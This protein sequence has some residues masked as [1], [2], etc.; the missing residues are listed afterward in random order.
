MI[1]IAMLVFA[2]SCLGPSTVCQSTACAEV[3]ASPRQSADAPVSTSLQNGR[4]LVA[5]SLPVFFLFFSHF[6][7]SRFVCGERCPRASQTGIN[8]E[9]CSSK[10]Q[11]RGLKFSEV[12][13]D[14]GGLGYPEY[15]G[16]SKVACKG[17]QTIHFAPSSRLLTSASVGFDHSPCGLPMA[18]L[19]PKP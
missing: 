4:R 2:L 15:R 12:C 17:P 16:L 9:T 1:E 19:K 7:R 10:K 6:V 11:V 8:M 13:K 5:A 18:S 14:L 3:E